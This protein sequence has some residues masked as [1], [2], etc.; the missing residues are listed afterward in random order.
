M[1]QAGDPQDRQCF[2]IKGLDCIAL[3][4][5]NTAVEDA[6]DLAESNMRMLALARAGGKMPTQDW[7]RAQGLLVNIAV[8]KSRRR[9][10]TITS[11]AP[12]PLCSPTACMCCLQNKDVVK[13]RCW[14]TDFDLRRSSLLK[15]DKTGKALMTI[16]RHLGR[17]HEVS[18]R[19]LSAA[20]GSGARLKSPSLVQARLPLGGKLESVYVLVPEE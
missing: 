13:G 3:A 4:Q 20:L 17:I 6:A 18:T 8:S 16:L 10:L 7:K 19:A 14:M 1:G 5:V 9:L 15:P 11:F 12:L 2:H